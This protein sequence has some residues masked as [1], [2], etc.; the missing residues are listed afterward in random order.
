MHKKNFHLKYFLIF[1]IQSYILSCSENMFLTS[2]CD[3]FQN[4][5]L[6][7]GTLRLKIAKILKKT[8]KVP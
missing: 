6:F 4:F 2:D 1:I 3:K 7:L 5:W 8:Q